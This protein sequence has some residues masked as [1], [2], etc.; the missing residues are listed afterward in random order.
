MK[1]IAVDAEN[2]V[3]AHEQAAKVLWPGEGTF[4]LPAFFVAALR[5][6]AISLAFTRIRI[7]NSICISKELL[8]KSRNGETA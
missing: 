3:L 5:P 8:C 6:S 2:A 1:E 7:Y 4:H